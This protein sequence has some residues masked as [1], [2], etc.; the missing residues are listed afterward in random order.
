MKTVSLPIRV[1]K[2]IFVAFTVKETF[3]EAKEIF[4]EMKEK[5]DQAGVLDGEIRGIICARIADFWENDVRR[6]F[7]NVRSKVEGWYNQHVKKWISKTRAYY[8]E[9]REG[10]GM[11][12]SFHRKS[13]IMIKITFA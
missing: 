8:L 7:A 11:G 10:N 12:I 4:D 13:R 3:D 6:A 9:R 5:L 2:L 1:L